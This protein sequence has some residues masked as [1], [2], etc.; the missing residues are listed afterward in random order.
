MAI[1]RDIVR[2]A[3]RKLNISGVGEALQPE[4][5]QEGID[6]LNSMVFGW[7]LRSVDLSWNEVS[8]N[9]TFP[10]HDEYIEGVI[11]LLAARLSADYV[12]PPSF[13]PD[14]WFRSIQ[15]NNHTISKATIPDGLLRMPSQVVTEKPST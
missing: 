9:D 13:N 10:L 11:Y 12:V 7:K 1:V 8:E 15:N 6:A 3:Y 5:L 14:A 2:R 4:E